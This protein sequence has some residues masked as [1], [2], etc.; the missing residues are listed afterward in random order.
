[1]QR[2]LGWILVVAMVN[3]GACRTRDPDA[4]GLLD[5]DPQLQKDEAAAIADEGIANDGNWRVTCKPA[6]G[7][8]D[9][10]YILLIHGA[11]SA[12]DETQPLRVSLA[13]ERSNGLETLSRDE[14]GRGAID[15][16]GALFVGFES[17]VLTGEAGTQQASYQG[18][19]TL[20]KDRDADALAVQCT[21][22]KASE[23]ATL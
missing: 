4:E 13:I 5:A 18:V 23:A 16:K 7:S 19:M 8:G 22:E 6:D 17:G 20:S 3:L 9:K 21:A 10:A 14:M 11:T 2:V 1:M 15:P 12:R